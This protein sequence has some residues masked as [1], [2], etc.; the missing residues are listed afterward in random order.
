MKEGLDGKPFA[1][2]DA[3]GAKSEICDENGKEVGM[4]KDQKIYKGQ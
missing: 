2:V 3:T 4:Y 1:V